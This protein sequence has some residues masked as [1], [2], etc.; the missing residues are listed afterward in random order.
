MVNCNSSLSDSFDMTRRSKS[1]FIDPYWLTLRTRHYRCS[2]GACH[3][4]QVKDNYY[5]IFNDMNS[6]KSCKYFILPILQEKCCVL[7]QVTECN[8]CEAH[9]TPL[10][11]MYVFVDLTVHQVQNVWQHGYHFDLTDQLKSHINLFLHNL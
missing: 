10:C 1:N 5:L 7:P 8:G 2:R 4:S 6:S 11:Y 3:L 9:Q